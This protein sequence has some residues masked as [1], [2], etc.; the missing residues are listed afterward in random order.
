QPLSVPSAPSR[1]L[2]LSKGAST[3]SATGIRGSSSSRPAEL[4]E[5]HT[6]PGSPHP[7][8]H[9][10]VVNR[11]GFRFEPLG[12]GVIGN[13]EDSD[14]FVLGSSPGTPAS[15]AREIGPFLCALHPIGV[16]I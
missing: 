1:S 2:S 15:K 12:Y 14:S 9:G 3:S 4:A 7:L 6:S 5:A 11:F 8:R 13:T 16:D 10:K